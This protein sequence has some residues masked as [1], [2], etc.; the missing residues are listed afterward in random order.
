MPIMPSGYD[1]TSGIFG[2]ALYHLNLGIVGQQQCPANITL[3]DPMES[4]T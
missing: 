4:S 3:P 2:G 1:P